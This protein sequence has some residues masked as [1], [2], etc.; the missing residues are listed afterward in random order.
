LILAIAALLALAPIGYAQTSS[1]N[2]SFLPSFNNSSKITGHF[3]HAKTGFLLTN[4]HASVPCESCHKLGKFEN[5]PTACGQCHNSGIASGMPANHPPTTQQCDGCHQ[6][7][8][9]KDIKTIDHTQAS[10][11]CAACHNGGIASGKPPGHIPTVAPCQACHQ[12]TISFG[13]A[14]AFQ[15]SPTDTNCSSCHNN[16][17]ATG[18]TSPPHIPVANVQCSSCHSNTYPSFSVPYY[19]MNHGA[20]EPADRCDLCHNGS[21]TGQGAKGA[22]G[23]A[24]FPNHV[25]TNG[26]DCLSCHQKAQLGGYVRWAGSGYVHT[27]ADAGKCSNCHNGATAT[28]QTSP[29]HIPVA[30]VQCDNCHADTNP[31]FNVPYYTM[32]H[33]AVEPVD[34]CDF[35][36]NGAFA[37]QGAMGAMGTASFPNHLATNGLDCLGCHQQAQLGGYVSWAGG[38]YA[39][40]PADA[41]KCSNCHNG[42]TATGEAS[43]PHI[44]VAGV[45]C[46]NC[47]SDA[48]PSFN[49]PYYTMSHA[50]VEPADRCDLCH[51]GA[52]VSQGTS[53]ATGTKA[54]PGHIPTNGLDC[55]SCHAQAQTGGYVTWAGGGY[56]HTPAD[57]GKCS[58]CHNGSTATGQTSPPHIPVAG[59]QCDN[60]HADTNPSF[61]V[62]YYTMNHGAVEPADRCDLCHNGNFVSQGTSGATGTKTYP[63]HIPTNGQDCLT[64]HTK[65]Q[66]GG[67]VSWA[68]TGNYTHS[69]A[70]NGKCSTCH[71]GTKATGETSPPHIPIGTVQCDSCHSYAGASF[72]TAPGYSGMG[73]TGHSAVI[74]ARCD[75]CHN[76]SYTAQGTTGA[77][78]T[79]NYA[80]HVATGGRDCI[81]CHT[82][83][84]SGGYASW[85]GGV[86]QHLATDTNCSS[87]HNGA[88]ATGMTTPPH[89]PI[90]GVQCSNCH[91][92]TAPSFTTYAMSHTTVVAAERCD[93]CHNGSY[94]GEGTNGAQ[95]SA[96]YPNHIATGGQDCVNC[97]A[98]AKS[99]G[100]ASWAG[101]TYAHTAAD[102]N[103]CSTCHNGAIALGQTS[104]PHIPVSGVQCNACHSD[105]G[106]AFNT[107]PGY[108]G[109]GSAGHG[110][111]TAD[112]CDLCHNGSYTTQGTTGAYSTANY[113]NHV[114]TNGLDCIACHSKAQSGGF[115]SWA[116]GAYA[117]QPTDTNCS[118]CHNGT[119][120]QGMTSP[121]HIPIAAVQ[122]SNC[123]ANTDPSF[124]VPYYTMAH[125]A[126]VPAE[127]CDACHNGSFTS[128]GSTGAIG[129]A[130]FANH[131][132]TNGQDCGVCHAKAQSGGYVSW[133]ATGVYAHSAADAGKCATCHNGATA[134][135]ETNPPHIPIGSAACDSCHSYSG[136][137]FATAPGYS[138]MGATGHG[139]I[140]SALRCDACHSGAYTSQGTS[141]GA[142]ANTSYPGHIP[143]NGADCVTCHTKA[144]SGGYVN[145]TGTG[146]YTHTAADAGK[147]SNCH[148]GAN[149]TGETSP[150]HIPIGAVQCDNCHS[151]AGTSFATAPGYSGMG[152]AGHGSVVP[153]TRC[154]ACHNGSYTSQGTSGGAIG[155]ASY[156][157]HVATNGKDCVTCHAAAQSGGYKTWSGTGAYTHTAADAGKCSNCHNGA[158]ATGQ[159]SPPHIPIGAVQCDNCHSYTGTNF[160][161]APGYSGMGATGHGAVV[162]TD[163]CDVC[164]NGNFTSQGT[165][166]AYATSNF[167]NHVATGGRDCVACHA[168]AQSG[169]YKSWSGG[170]YVHLATDTNC[171]ACHNGATATGMTTPPHI[172]SGA[173]QCSS[174]H[175]STGASFATAPGY[176]GMGSTG[177]SAVGAMRCDACH[178]GSFTS[179]G[180]TGAYSTSNFANHVATA[181]RDCITCHATAQ[182][183][184]YKSWSG[185]IY[186]HQ[187]TDTNCSTCH[188]GATATGMTSPPHI[189]SGAVQ[190]SACHSNTGSSFSAAPGYS[191][192]GTTGHSAVSALACGACHNGSYVSQGAGGGAMAT[193]SY[194]N[195]VATGGRDCL[196]CHAQSQANG[197]ISWSG[198]VYTHQATDTN[199]STCHNGAIAQGMTSPP[200]IP[201]GAVQCSSCHNNTGSSFS[202]APGYSGMGAAGH[203][204]VSAMR[205]D[206]CHNGSYT[207]QGTVGATANTSYPGHVPTN[208][209][210]C[211]TCHAKAKSGGFLTWAGTGTFTHTA[212]DT[213]CSSCHNG[214]TATGMVTPPHI[215]INGAQC[216][217]CHSNTGTSFSVAPGYLGMGTTGHAVVTTLRCDACHDGAY[218]TQGT[219]GAIANTSYPGHVP[220][221]GA[222][223]VTCH[224]AAK[225]G[226][227][228][229]WA[230]TGTFTH[231]SADTACS[232]CHNGTTAT[233]H[234]TPPHVPVTGIQCSGC[235]SYAGTSFSASPGYTGMG[236][237]GHSVVHATRCDACHN[238]SYTN[239]GTSG[240]A[241]GPDHSMKTQ[242]CGCCHNKAAATFTSWSGTQS[243]GTCTTTAKSPVAAKHVMVRN[244][245]YVNSMVPAGAGAVSLKTGTPAKG[246][247][248]PTGT[249][250]KSQATP[251]TGTPAKGQAT[252]A[253]G[254]P[255]K[256]QA[257]P[258][259]TPAKGAPAAAPTTI[260]RP[261]P[262]PTT[263]VGHPPVTAPCATCHNGAAAPGKPARHIPTTLSCEACHKSTRTFAGVVFDHR[264]TM[265]P[266]ATCHDGSRAKG[267]TVRHVPT[268]APCET[269]HKSPRTF[270]GAL[271]DHKAVTS[272]C[273]ACHNNLLATGKPPKHLAT[274]ANCDS[275]HKSTVDW[276]Q[277]K[278][279]HKTTTQACAQCHNGVAATGKPS[280]HLATTMPCDTCHKS[281]DRFSLVQFDHG[282]AIAPCLTCHNGVMAEGKP[283]GHVV[284][285]AP[286]ED[287][288]ISTR[289]FLLVKPASGPR[290]R[291]IVR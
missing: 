191:G 106:A 267:K 288:H 192:M 279:D 170:A 209:A 224:A 163:R 94:S 251:T 98:T 25:A 278:F 14:V 33:A 161:V 105:T 143:T 172:P 273:L 46:D 75:A 255:A 208:G 147:C 101:G 18:E 240:G 36:H 52:F 238:G 145:W 110:A 205:C 58:T 60:C 249:P 243:P 164:H 183:S 27:P 207:S 271:V 73:V 127:R 51:N 119:T 171:S 5:T 40:T 241:R 206:A 217:A 63:G 125:A 265:A 244:L 235:H 264:T 181:G 263:I 169:G 257:T 284:T 41:G 89:V 150:P 239:Q 176:S 76:G 200:H 277:S 8:S 221:N 13:I 34:R 87:C 130:S 28:G 35:C 29:P 136:T 146:A 3:D 178:N 15:H 180:T 10:K 157:G 90:V 135:G 67:Y 216:S 246:Q 54:Y 220:T 272:P 174:C 229:S 193:T 131:M 227:Y 137:S 39:H 234:T 109:M 156:P 226:G 80:N 56:A 215:P 43:P 139:A 44:P 121:P 86:Y 202:V 17:Q 231:T 269:C 287:C 68:G 245:R 144:Q 132:A 112:R 42:S 230:K 194:A 276:A 182:S 84:K 187:A 57:A 190:C 155:T 184:G 162:P 123:H 99:G 237:P 22:V 189:P 256:G 120:A 19:T 186:V 250:A 173:V 275:C 175:S 111:V 2:A 219:T 158:T 236:T 9:F 282:A 7:S 148:N 262:S 166:G 223:C 108:S 134:T 204:T 152:A 100:Y 195:H 160:A 88:T 185:G 253:T 61:N 211:I 122:C 168:T 70:D 129:S 291:A 252:P 198:G 93:A 270:G 214:T 188:N 142:T 266:C 261:S 128:Q 233:G 47:H 151:Y 6:T 77:Y 48:Y 167:A 65:A 79:T 64:C 66:T 177:H 212:A 72:A 103:S 225:S 45:Q 286:C 285:N 126:V 133:V 95:G 74:A 62:P 138:G 82:T 149:A 92:N 4:S 53:G 26:L 107:A 203:N 213:N 30:G 31:S 83:A 85:S 232:S 153:A 115:V 248:T 102:A 289:S 32:S 222:D 218:T 290:R 281:T 24:S 78:A 113:A 59:V 50:V 1:P 210:D 96:S 141:G 196:V 118:N 37:S 116:G 247:T 117:H 81:V 55:L 154:D 159:T 124:N 20:V 16:V 71:N 104:P 179:Q 114:A 23:T 69:S 228:L 21:F 201:S 259:G 260:S 197:Y 11:V 165:T 91:T 280:K 283:V 274:V 140:V 199:C 12:S 258:T 254:T 97:H 49:V 268:A 242:D 38:G